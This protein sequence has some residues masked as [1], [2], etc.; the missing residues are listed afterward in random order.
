M[1]NLISVCLGVVTAIVPS[2]VFKK[3]L[4]NNINSTPSIFV[5]K[6]YYAQ[7]IKMLMII[8]LLALCY[9]KL[10]TTA[11]WLTTSFVVTYITVMILTIFRYMKK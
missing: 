5:K 8:S 10:K 11:S 2:Y 4:L 7:I 6:L 1:Q 9:I 3:I